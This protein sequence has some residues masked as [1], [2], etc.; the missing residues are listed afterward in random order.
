VARYRVG[1]ETR[2]RIL[3]ATREVLGEQGLENA[4]LKAI[5]DRAGVGAGSFYNLFGS[6]EEAVL[7]VMRE[8][9]VAVDPDPAGLGREGLDDLIEAF[10][11][12]VTGPSSTLARIHLQLAGSA[13]TDARVAGRLRRSHERRVERFAAATRR[14]HPDVSAAGAEAHAELLLAALTGLALRWILDPDFDMAAHA[15]LLPRRP[16]PAIVEPR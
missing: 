10:V 12:F 7:E 4:T 2:E 1:L 3:R 14:E 9:I 11:L 6:K 15:A 8:A 16:V 13:L 5:T